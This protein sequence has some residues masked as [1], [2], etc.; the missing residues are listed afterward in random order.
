MGGDCRYHIFLFGS[1]HFLGLFSS[2]K[3]PHSLSLVLPQKL[4][5]WKGGTYPER[6]EFFSSTNWLLPTLIFKK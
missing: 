2:E 6:E 3:L 4:I 1:I 5:A